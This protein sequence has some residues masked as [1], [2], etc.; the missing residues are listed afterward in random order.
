M[1][2]RLLYYYNINNVVALIIDALSE[3]F[4]SFDDSPARLDS[5]EFAMLCR[6]TLAQ[7]VELVAFNH[8][9]VGLIPT[10]DDSCCIHVTNV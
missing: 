1:W 3:F 7:S 9:A 10:D 6:V 8:A 5:I 4:A 2:Q